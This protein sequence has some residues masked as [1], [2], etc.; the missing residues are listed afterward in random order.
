MN[1]LFDLFD[2][3]RA[4]YRT[5]RAAKA[6]ADLQAGADILAKAQA[7]A[8]EINTAASAVTLKP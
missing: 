6:A 2:R 4:S 5:R 8:T 3:I 7:E 1:W